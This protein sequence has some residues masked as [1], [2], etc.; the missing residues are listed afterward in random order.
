MIH[1]LLWLLVDMVELQK[2]AFRV[3]QHTETRC[4]N[5]VRILETQLSHVLLAS[6]RGV[7]S[8]F[9]W[10]KFSQCLPPA[11]LSLHLHLFVLLTKEPA[12]VLMSTEAISQ[13]QIEAQECAQPI[14]HYDTNNG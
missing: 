9:I 8:V 14:N 13:M 1:A 12:M 4:Q 2:A 5:L 7:T 11:F 10:Q 6:A 3:M